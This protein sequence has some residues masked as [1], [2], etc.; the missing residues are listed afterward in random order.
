V[1]ATIAAPCA[2]ETVAVESASQ[3]TPPAP[4]APAALTLSDADVAA[5]SYLVRTIIE[6]DPKLAQQRRQLADEMLKAIRQGR[7]ELSCLKY[8][9]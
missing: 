4:Q 1:A 2:V 7:S 5:I 6:T 9:P 3:V 8:Q